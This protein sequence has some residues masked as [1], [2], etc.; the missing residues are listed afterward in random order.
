MADIT[1][2]QLSDRFPSAKNL[3]K[4]N[5]ETV[6]LKILEAQ[7]LLNKEDLGER[8]ST[9][10]GYKVMQLLAIACGQAKYEGGKWVTPYDSVPDTAG[11]AI[12]CRV[13]NLAYGY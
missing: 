10:L 13:T 5:P 9:V 6:E 7:A 11:H 4:C 3:I 8:Y 2:Q 1:I 12:G